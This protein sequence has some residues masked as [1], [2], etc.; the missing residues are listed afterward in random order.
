MELKKQV[1]SLELSKKLKELGVKQESLFEWRQFDIQEEMKWIIVE[2]GKIPHKMG[3][4]NIGFGEYSA[5]TVAELGEIL[6]PQGHQLPV[7]SKKYGVFHSDCGGF[8]GSVW[9]QDK[10]EANARAKML[11]HLIEKE[12]VKP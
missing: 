11:I 8:F 7:W 10:T 9:I 4:A 2:T 5:F 3:M 12:I 1:C 6:K